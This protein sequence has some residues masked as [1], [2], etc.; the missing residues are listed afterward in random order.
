MAD[1]AMPLWKQADSI[2]TKLVDC[3]KKTYS[4]ISRGNYD[5]AERS[6][7]DLKKLAA[8]LTS[9]LDAVSK[10]LVKTDFSADLKQ[11]QAEGMG[12]RGKK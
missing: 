8:D 10:I 7:K 2:H 4:S 5:E 9:Q 6:F 1:E 11:R 12:P 3:G